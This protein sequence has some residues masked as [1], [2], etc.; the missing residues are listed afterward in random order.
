VFFIFPDFLIV[1]V[2]PPA[3]QVRLSELS[4]HSPPDVRGSGA[5]AARAVLAGLRE[6]AAGDVGGGGGS[7]QAPATSAASSW[8]QRV[9]SLTNAIAKEQALLQKLS[10][11]GRGGASK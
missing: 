1:L 10:T 6:A 2:S 3:L 7:A 4:A 5:Y 9:T 11:T 8:A